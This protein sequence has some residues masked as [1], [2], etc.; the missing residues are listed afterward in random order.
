MALYEKLE[1]ELEILTPAFIGGAFPSEKAEL[2]PASFIGILRWWF[3][4]L[5]LTFTNKVDEIFQVESELFGNIQKAGKIWVKFE[6]L[7]EKEYSFL[8]VEEEYSFLKEK[9]ISPNLAYLGYGNFMF[10]NCSKNFSK[11]PHVCENKL[12]F[13]GNINVKAFLPAK[14]LVRVSILVPKKY[15]KLLENLLYIVSQLGAIGGRNRR[16]WGNFYLNPVRN[17][18]I[19]KI[20]WNPHTIREKYQNFINELKSLRI[21]SFNTPQSAQ[22][23]EIYEKHFR[24]SNYLNVLEKLGEAYNLFRKRLNPDYQQLKNFLL[25]KGYSQYIIYN[26]A[27]FGLP[28]NV[29]YKKG[30]SATINVF[31]SNVQERL[32]SPLIF[33]VFRDSNSFYGALFIVF[34]RRSFIERKNK[35]YRWKLSN[36]EKSDRKVLATAKNL[37]KK[38]VYMN[39]PFDEFIKEFFSKKFVRARHILTWPEN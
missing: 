32:A 11:Y 33:R 7:V 36:N 13:K 14:S 28:I 9:G 26:R 19:E 37:P 1:Y 39:I 4:N 27:W 5:A 6:K 25:R 16:G 12:A 24:E 3:R 20:Y 22:T 23:I 31:H 10:V 17:G 18:R 2:R 34:K 15:K 8:L 38:P 29:R 35:F 21:F 30:K